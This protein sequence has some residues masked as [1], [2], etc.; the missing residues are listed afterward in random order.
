MYKMV[1]IVVILVI[2]DEEN[3]G[4]VEIIEFEKVWFG[5]DNKV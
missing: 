2:G 1:L 5:W 3:K 4:W